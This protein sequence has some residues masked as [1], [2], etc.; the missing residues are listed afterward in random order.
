MIRT[1][2]PPIDLFEDIAA[3]A[4]WE[5]LANAEMKTNPRVRDAIGAI[6]LVPIEQRVSGPGASFVMAPFCHCSSDRPSRFSDRSY[7][8]YYAGDRLE[9]ALHE[10]I[11]HFERFMAATME[12]AGGAD[13]R[14]LVGTVDNRFHDIR[15]DHAYADCLDPAAYGIAQALGRELRDRQQS[16]GLVYPSVRHPAG[17]AVAVFRPNAVG[18]P[19]QARQF[20][21]WWNGKG[22]DRYIEYGRDDWIE[23]TG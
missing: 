3:P 11:F 19:V 9:V 4:D 5:L 1:I 8:V 18:I 23:L 15:N 13:F 14:E 2:Y 20:Q 7:G 17:L 6:N 21:Y 16:N 12:P 22:V 10:T